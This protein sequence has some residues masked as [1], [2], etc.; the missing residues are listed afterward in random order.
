MHTFLMIV[1]FFCLQ[2]TVEHSTDT[3]ATTPKMETQTTQDTTTTRPDSQ[4]ETVQ[5]TI[6]LRDLLII[7]V[8][9]FVIDVLTVNID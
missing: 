1:V 4:I 2:P 7:V 8:G 6:S 5:D 3:T 9:E